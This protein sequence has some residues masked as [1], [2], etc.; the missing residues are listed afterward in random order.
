M[1]HRR[2]LRSRLKFQRLTVNFGEFM[3]VAQYGSKY[4]SFF[5]NFVSIVPRARSSVIFAGLCVSFLSACG[6]GAAGSGTSTPG[7]YTLSANVSNLSASGLVISD[8]SH[9]LEV[10]ANTTNIVLPTR[11]ASGATYSVTIVTQ[12]PGFTDVCS[13]SNASG[14]INNSDVTSINIACHTARAVVTTFAGSSVQGQING[15]G[16]AASFYN[17][18]SVTLDGAGNIYVADYNNG[19]VR[20]ITPAGLVST[21]AGGSGLGG[22]QNG[23]GSVATFHGAWAVAADASG[24]VYVADNFNNMIRRVTSTGVVTTFAGIKQPGSV[25]GPGPGASFHMPL[26]VAVDATNNV[27]VADSYN[28][29]IRKITPSGVVSTL[30]GSGTMGKT[31]GVGAAA[32][33]YM[34]HG[35]A[36]DGSGNVYVADMGNYAVRKITPTGTVTTLAD[37]TAIYGSPSGTGLNPGFGGISGIAV[38]VGGNVYTADTFTFLILKITPAGKVSTLA[39][40]NSG[41][42]AAGISDQGGSANGIGIA[43]SFRWPSGLAIDG[44]GNLY[45]ADA[46]NNLIRKISPQ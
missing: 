21:L 4:I 26:G 36:V 11:L 13:V 3:S 23:T 37:A 27:Y 18:N 25:D 39:G 12:P 19:A 29:L 41:N 42:S 17:P 40:I 5:R 8:G 6:G 9:T 46:G 20:K 28:N 44:A 16:T 7:S 45:V 32:S 14:T 31:D 2:R 22:S 30:A 35:L 33:F 10:P 24:N 1:F 38:D 15:M 34:P 43:A